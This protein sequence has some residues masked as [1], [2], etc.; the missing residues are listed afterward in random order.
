MKYLVLKNVAVPLGPK[1]VIQTVGDAGV[2]VYLDGVR[3]ASP[4]SYS[5]VQEMLRELNDK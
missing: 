3:Y 5:T 2:Y 1:T 4:E